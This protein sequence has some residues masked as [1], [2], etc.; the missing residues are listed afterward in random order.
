MVSVTVIIPTHNRAGIINFAIQSVLSQTYTDFELIVV[1]DASKDQ[2]EDHVKSWNDPRIKYVRHSSSKGGSAAR[3]TG[4]RIA[5][6]EYITFLDD[7]DQWVPSKLLKQLTLIKHSDSSV[8]LIYS[9][10]SIIKGKDI[11]KIVIPDCKKQMFFD[12]LESNC[13][14]PTSTVM[15][16]KTVIDEIGGFDE[17]LQSCQDWDLWLRIAEKFNFACIPEALVK[18]YL[19]NISITSNISNQL[20][21]HIQFFDKHQCNLSKGNLFCFLRIG[22]LFCLYGDAATGRRY[23]LKA[24]TKNFKDYRILFHFILSLFGSK[25]FCKVHHTLETADLPYLL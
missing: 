4:I 18:Y 2:T 1:D 8:G 12:L 15:I 14:G 20:R 9:G 19:T 10:Y 7:D 25:I 3:N 21:G 11:L 22:E 24:L 23:L 6:G 5:R 16:K 17:K 13:V